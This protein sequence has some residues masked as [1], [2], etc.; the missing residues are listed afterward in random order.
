MKLEQ[1][2]IL[3]KDVIQKLAQTTGIGSR[4]IQNTLSE[5]EKHGI[6]TSANRTKIRIQLQD[7]FDEFE[8]NA[9]RQKVHSFFLNQ[10][11]PTL[12]KLL[13]AINEDEDL[14]NIKRSSLHK[15]L[16]IL[17]FKYVKRQ[18]N[19]YLS[20]RTD[21]L[22]WRR[23]YIMLIKK[24]RDEKRTIYYLDET[25]VNAG[26]VTEKV[27]MDTTIKSNR[28]AH[29]R[30]LSTGP[31]N[32]V[33]KGKR[34]IVLHI[35]SSDGFVPGGL[36]CFESKKS[37]GDY[38]DEMNGEN[39]L[40]WFKMILPKLDEN[41][42]I[43]MDNAPY[44]SVKCEKIPHMGWIKND[45]Q[46]WLREKGYQELDNSMTK[47][48]LMEIV[49]KIKS[50]YNKYEVDELAN[51]FNRLVLRL[52]PY[53][54][55]LNPI[56]MI[57]AIVKGYVK[58]NNSTFKFRDVKELLEKGIKSVTS[59]NWRKCVEHTKK[60][61]EKLLSIEGILDSLHDELVIN[62]NAESSSDSESSS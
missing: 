22:K 38:H 12:D 29:L 47:S 56:E 6:V 28:D 17:N 44:H 55:E 50:Q 25:W 62:V 54:C 53:H 21:L 7:K 52:P 46:N 59:E 37:T 51:K 1:P 14:P 39:F 58:K 33:G 45:I 36:L 60:E 40:N 42:V 23:D 10:E 13:A 24:Y 27:W 35:G 15:L 31:K 2:G 48:M 43:V 49:N 8:K 57:W 32:P 16:K 20:E 41:C 9:I 30:G 34:L 3:K 18:R 19:S 26:D 4:S 11:L 61:E 5:Y